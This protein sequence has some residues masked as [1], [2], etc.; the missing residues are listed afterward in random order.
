MTEPIREVQRAVRQAAD[1]RSA[2]I[3]DAANNG[4]QFVATIDSVIPGGAA[5]GVNALVTIDWLGEVVTVNGYSRG[6]T[7]VEGHRV[8]CDLIKDQIFIVY[9]PVG[10][11]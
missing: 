11:P 5:D 4:G 10:Q 7:P 9:S 3:A 2:R 1:A 6:Y 8:V